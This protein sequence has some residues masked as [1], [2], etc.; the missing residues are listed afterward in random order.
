MAACNIKHLP[1]AEGTSAAAAAPA[2]A[3]AVEIKQEVDEQ[4]A[5]E[6]WGR[7][8]SCGADG[9]RVTISLTHELW[10]GWGGAVGKHR[11]GGKGPGRGELWIYC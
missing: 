3:T 1:P 2:A 7:T 8:N 9:K 5:L 11:A 4:E 10:K 6:A